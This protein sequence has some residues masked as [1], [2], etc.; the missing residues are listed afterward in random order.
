MGSF[1]AVARLDDI[2]PGEVISAQVDGTWVAIARDSRGDV[3]ALE[4]RCSH[5]DIPLS[6][7]DVDGGALEC[8]KHGSE[9]DLATGRPRQLPAVLPVP[10]YPVR[11]DDDGTIAV[12]VSAPLTF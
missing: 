2:A 4:D 12:D 3:H 1:T 5:D 6:D 11:I 10:V 7:G 9:F 8:W